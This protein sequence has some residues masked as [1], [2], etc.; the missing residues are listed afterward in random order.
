MPEKKNIDLIIYSILE[1]SASAT[2]K[3]KHF[4]SLIRMVRI[5]FDEETLTLK[6]IHYYRY[7]SRILK[8]RVFQIDCL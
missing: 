4:N 5:L 2:P 7:P 6:F 8:R 3:P 1:Y